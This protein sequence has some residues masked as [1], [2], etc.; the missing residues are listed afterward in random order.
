MTF[1]RTSDDYPCHAINDFNLDTPSR[2]AAD[3]LSRNWK[4]PRKFCVSVVITRAIAARS[5]LDF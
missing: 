5:K 3:P 4:P 2:L 1:D